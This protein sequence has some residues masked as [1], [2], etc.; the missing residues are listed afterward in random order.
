VDPGKK[1]ESVERFRLAVL[2][3]FPQPGGQAAMDRLGLLEES[4]LVRIVIRNAHR[5][6]QRV[7][8]TLIST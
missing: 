1:L 5:F 7:F 6:R 8:K 4:L 3:A 2:G